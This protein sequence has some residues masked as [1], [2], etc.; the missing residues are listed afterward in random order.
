MGPARRRL[1]ELLRGRR[2]TGL[3]T[4]FALSF[5][6]V[7]AAVTVL[8]GLLSYTAAARL[9]RVDQESVFSEVVRDLRGE[10]RRRPMTTRDFSSSAPGHD[11]VRPARTDV[12]VLGPDGAVVD[13]GRPGLPV[14]AADRRIATDPTAGRLVEHKDV[15]VGSDVYRVATVALGGGRGAV[16]VAQEFSDTEDLLRALQQRTLLLMAAV[17]T[18]AGL[19]GWWLARRI[20]RRLVVLTA[21]VYK[22][23]SPGRPDRRRRGRRPHPP[24]RHPGTGHRIRRGGPAGP[25]LRPH[26]GPAGPVRGGPATPRAGRG[27]RAAHPA[28]L[29]AHEHLPA[30]PHRRTAARH[31]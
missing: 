29:P 25:R 13:P 14:T 22:R 20:T 23:Q 26:A 24:P 3:G 1:G 9:V 5:A 12:Q 10:V 27:P 28:D 18:L 30:A 21:D 6:A 31:P 19:F 16:Q 8:V 4:T 11:L 7:T 17:V 15:D 2:R